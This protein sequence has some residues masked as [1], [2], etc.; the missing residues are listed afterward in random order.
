MAL[1]MSQL[2]GWMAIAD[3]APIQLES[4]ILVEVRGRVKRPGIFSLASGSRGF[5]AIRQA[6]GPLA[7]A[8]LGSIQLARPLADG[9]TLTVTRQDLTKSPPPEHGRARKRGNS[10]P[11]RVGRSPG[12]KLSL[13]TATVAQLDTLPGIGPRLAA[14]IIALRESR[15][16]LQ[17]LDDLDTIRGLGPKRIDRLRPLL[18]P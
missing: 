7:D 16:G 3:A 2:P 9:E 13:N 8:D 14:Q 18:E 12:G 11:R 5:E 1:A 15:H 6:G 17:S 4:H 10:R